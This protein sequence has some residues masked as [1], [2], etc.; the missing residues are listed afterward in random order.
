MRAIFLI[1]LFIG[2]GSILLVLHFPAQAPTSLSITVT[3]TNVTSTA[4]VKLDQFLATVTAIPPGEHKS[5]TITLSD[6]ELLT[7]LQQLTPPS[8]KY[9]LHIDQVHIAPT[10]VTVSG[11]GKVDGFNVRLSGIAQVSAYNG[12]LHIAL[13]TLSASSLPVP[14]TLRSALQ[15]SINR[16]LQIEQRLIPIT[17]QNVTQGDHQITLTGKT[18]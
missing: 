1:V 17:V 9:N 6:Y 18:R 4:D 3:T 7:L 10:G 14:P 5:V 11:I 12:A 13:S 15:T 8:P 16:H 2:I